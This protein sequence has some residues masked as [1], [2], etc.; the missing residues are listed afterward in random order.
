MAASGVRQPAAL[1]VG[2]DDGRQNGGAD[3]VGVWAK[4]VDRA[5][6]APVGQPPALRQRG[7][8]GCGWSMLWRDRWSYA[9]DDRLAVTWFGLRHG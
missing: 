2:S 3:E 7:A 6:G 4:G 5:G 9:R 1:Q 8:G